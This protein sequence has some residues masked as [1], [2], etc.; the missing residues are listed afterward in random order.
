MTS[1]SKT[2]TACRNDRRR[3]GS[4]AVLL[5]EP[6]AP[7]FA[8]VIARAEDTWISVVN[9]LEVAISVDRAGKDS[10]SLAFDRFT[11]ARRIAVRPAR[12]RKRSRH[13]RLALTG[14]EPALPQG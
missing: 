2:S 1:F 12:L 13:E 10:T 7:L 11:A 14:I 9:W 3:L 8:E 4:L 6:D 5:D